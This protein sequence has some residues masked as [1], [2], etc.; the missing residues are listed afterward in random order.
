[1]LGRLEH[2]NRPFWTGLKGH[3]SLAAR[4]PE[5]R[6]ATVACDDPG[7]EFFWRPRLDLLKSAFQAVAGGA[8][9]VELRFARVERSGAANGSGE[10]DRARSFKKEALEHPLVRDA[11]DLFDAD[12]EEIRALKP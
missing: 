12:V 4:D 9:R 3:G 6:S 8:V 1:M 2:T 5:R 11:P 10:W 7:Q